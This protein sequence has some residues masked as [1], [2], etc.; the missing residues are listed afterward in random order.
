MIQ[1]G[2]Q[3]CKITKVT[4]KDTKKDGSP[5]IDKNG[6]KFKMVYI[7]TD[8]MGKDEIASCYCNSP[9]KKELGLN[10][11]DEVELVFER[12]GN[13]LNFSMPSQLDQL[14]AELIALTIRVNKLEGGTSFKSNLTPEET[15]KIQA[16]RENAT[17]GQTADNKTSDGSDMPNF[18]LPTNW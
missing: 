18:D 9:A 11:G 4:I 1:N 13:F 5:N 12:S 16:H 8:T 3:K 6:K 7:Q 14:R 2:L 10:V 17:K 15:S